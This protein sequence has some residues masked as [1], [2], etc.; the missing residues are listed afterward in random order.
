MTR[1]RSTPWLHRW[2]RPLIGTIAI[3]GA[4]NTGYITYTKFFGGEVTCPTSGCEQVL[5]SAYATVLGQ[6]LALFG[7]LAYVAMAVLALA[8]L[9]IDAERQKALRLKVEDLTWLLLFLGA[10]AM[11][12]FS[13]Y[14]M[15]VMFTQFV[16]PYGWK[17]LCFYCVASATFATAMFVL[18]LLGRTWEDIGQ[19]FFSGIVVGMV[20]LV[21]TLGVYSHIGKAVD[22]AYN[23]TSGSGQIT[24]TVQDTSGE[25]E[26]ELAKHLKN[27]GAKMY[28]AYW[29][30]HCYEQKKV[31]GVEALQA[32]LI[33]FVECAAD[34]V[35]AQPALCQEVA[36]KVQ[37]ATGKGFGFPTWEINGQYY[38]G[39][40]PL[41]ELAKISGYK[42]PSNFK[43]SF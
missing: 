4:L 33:P 43:N 15:Y 3:L 21:A 32:K 6:P 2:S 17:A 36:T 22:G 9:T 42:G 14:L 19:L 27:V 12:L 20:T 23:I 38:A 16:L 37:K 28:S 7:W 25:A 1:R 13:S 26:L 11:L 30:P 31:F 39:Q 8:P 24:F 41:T 34:G 40:Q 18:T 10:T 35:D 29:C 5:S